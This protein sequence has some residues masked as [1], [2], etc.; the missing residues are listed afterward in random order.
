MPTGLVQMTQLLSVVLQIQCCF[1]STETVWAIR[2]GEPRTATPTFTQLLSSELCYSYLTAHIAHSE[3][4]QDPSLAVQVPLEFI[5]H[6]HD[7]DRHDHA[8]G[9]VDKIGHRAQRNDVRWPGEHVAGTHRSGVLSSTLLEQFQFSLSESRL[10]QLRRHFVE[11][12]SRCKIPFSHK[13][14]G[15]RVSC[16]MLN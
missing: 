1:T 8:I 11:N 9:W 4:R 15:N 13:M 6:R 5:G 3:R 7:G 14:E 2:D 16:E 10:S 12:Q